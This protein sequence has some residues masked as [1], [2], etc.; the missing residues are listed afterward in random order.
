MRNYYTYCCDEGNVFDTLPLTFNIKMG[1][2]D[3]EFIK[4]TR[5]YEEEKAK[6]K[7]NKFRKN[8]WI[9]K[10]GENSNRGNGIKVE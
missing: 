7:I 1:H 9:I 8:I 2:D 5:Y 6:C 10:P 4:F 3:P